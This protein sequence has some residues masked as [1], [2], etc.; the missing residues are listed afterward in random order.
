[1]KNLVYSAA[2]VLCALALS[3]PAFAN[4]APVPR[5]S[6]GS[7]FFTSPIVPIICIIVII[8]V[9]LLVKTIVSNK[10]KK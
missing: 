7:G 6:Q 8:A 2:L 4:I 3:V 1:M 9:V 5:P 10:K